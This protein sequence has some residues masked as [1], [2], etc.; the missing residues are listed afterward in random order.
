MTSVAIMQPYFFPYAGYFRL[1]AAADLFVIYD[2][3][4]FPRRGWVHRNRLPD[5]HGQPRWLT[6]P[7]RRQA[8][9]VLIKDIAFAADAATRG[10]R[11]LRPFPSLRAAAARDEPLIEVAGVMDGPPIDYLENTL[12]RACAMLD[13]PFHTLRSSS[14]NIDPALGGE[15]R[16]IAIAR[17]LGARTYVNSP[18]GRR[19]YN[20]EVF[21]R[22]DLRLRFLEPYRGPH[23]SMLHRLVDEPTREI[24]GE[25]RSQVATSD[26][27]DC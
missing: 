13:L 21:A 3:V 16:I 2:C 7:L 27:G 20:P 22:H 25:I 18:G 14:L 17:R 1:F 4:Q 24:A 6:L 5:S 23:W 26:G 12:R 15:Q 8:R 11:L 9:S 10:R 19:L